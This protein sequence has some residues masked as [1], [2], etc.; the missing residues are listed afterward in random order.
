MTWKYAIINSTTLPT[1]HTSYNHKRKV[2]IELE[3]EV[4]E[5]FDT[6]ELDFTELLDLEPSEEVYVTVTEYSELDIL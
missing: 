6:R 4:F 1:M 3:L 2:L 5:D